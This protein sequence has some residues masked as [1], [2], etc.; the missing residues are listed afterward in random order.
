[1]SDR[2]KS[3]SAI[4]PAEGHSGLAVGRAKVG[5]VVLVQIEGGLEA[6]RAAD[7]GE[8]CLFAQNVEQHEEQV[9]VAD[10]N[11]GMHV[12]CGWLRGWR[13]RN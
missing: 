2:A 5:K 9:A 7:R 8:V 6:N 4:R 13:V 1:M 10:H 3:S 12:V 11:V